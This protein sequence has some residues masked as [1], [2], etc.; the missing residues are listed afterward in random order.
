MTYS[1]TIQAIANN[2][3]ERFCEVY[4]SAELIFLTDENKKQV[5]FPAINKDQEW[6]KLA[7]EDTE[8]T[9]YI[10]RNGDDEVFEELRI[11]SCSKAYRMRSPLRIVYFRDNTKSSEEP[12]FKLMQSV[13]LSNTRLRGIIRDKF[14]LL[15]DESTGDYSFKPT[16]VYLAIDIYAFWELQPDVCEQDFCIDIDNPIIKCEAVESGS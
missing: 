1:E 3:A 6:I 11:S 14:K 9:L 12:M 8:E 10:R 13:L 15:K 2:L 5:K 16:T 7:P 4:H